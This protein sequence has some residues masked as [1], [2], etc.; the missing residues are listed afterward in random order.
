MYVYDRPC[1]PSWYAARLEGQVV[2]V[3]EDS[4]NTRR[5]VGLAAKQFL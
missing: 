3:R 4:R 2:E 1:L 5:S